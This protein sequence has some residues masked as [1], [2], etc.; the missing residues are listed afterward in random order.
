MRHIC[1]IYY[2]QTDV[3]LP[4]R[5]VNGVGMPYARE[6]SPISDNA[7]AFVNP[8]SIVFC[9]DFCRIRC[10]HDERLLYGPLIDDSVVFQHDGPNN[11]PYF[12]L[13]G[14]AIKSLGKAHS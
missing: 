7:V 1:T 6:V 12:L 4:A 5:S 14:L 2:T 9:G 10:L 8:N 3:S 13:L 11:F